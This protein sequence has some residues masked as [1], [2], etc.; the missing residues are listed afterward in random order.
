MGLS[1]YKARLGE[2]DALIWGRPQSVE[3]EESRLRLVRE[4]DR[5]W[6][7]LT[8]PEQDEAVGNAVTLYRNR[9]SLPACEVTNPE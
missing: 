7:Q 6:P 2:Y 3:R 8:R 9:T 1:D 5:L 4:M